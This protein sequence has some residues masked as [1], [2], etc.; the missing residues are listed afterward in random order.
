MNP[1]STNNKHV[2]M[3]SQNLH[4]GTLAERLGH[5]QRESIVTYLLN[6]KNELARVETPSTFIKDVVAFRVPYFNVSPAP[7]ELGD[8]NGYV[9]LLVSDRIGGAVPA[10]SSSTYLSVDAQAGRGD[11]VT[12]VI[13]HQVVSTM[14][15]G[16]NDCVREKTRE[17]WVYFDQPQTL[18]RFDWRLS[19]WDNFTLSFAG[20]Y[21]VEAVIE[22]LKREC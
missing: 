6:A 12:N 19:L 15:G 17:Q 4:I 2:L 20:V 1:C 13:A 21:I 11:P 18:D 14:S 22:F 8:V 9:L 5:W 3:Y 10:L 7:T 16:P